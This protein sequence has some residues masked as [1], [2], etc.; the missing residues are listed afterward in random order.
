MPCLLT[1][2]LSIGG[3]ITMQ[4]QLGHKG[5][6]L[7]IVSGGQTG[8]DRAALDVA[9]GLGLAIGGWCPSGRRAADGVIPQHYPLIE[10]PSSRYAQRTEWNV[11][12]TDATL[13]LACGPLTGGTRLTA[14]LAR[15]HQRPCQIVDLGQPSAVLEINAWLREN[16]V[17]RLNI[18]GPREASCPGIYERARRF[19]HGLLT[20]YGH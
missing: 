1:L 16:H 12:D 17:Y 15:R 18:A 2:E 5:R 11:R 14:A 9:S 20:A 3:Q 4:D 19:L 6:M 7:E 8:V 10:T 13:V